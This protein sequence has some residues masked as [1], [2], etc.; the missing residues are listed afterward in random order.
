MGR[1]PVAFAMVTMVVAT[2]EP[3]G[4]HGWRRSDIFERVS[5]AG[6]MGTIFAGSSCWL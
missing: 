5:P 4:R 3:V 2:A 1:G 6:T